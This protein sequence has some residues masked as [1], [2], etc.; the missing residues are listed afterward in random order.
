VPLPKIILS[1]LLTALVFFAIDMVWL[2]VVAKN[3]YQKHLGHLLRSD[4]NWVAAISFYLLFI[5]GILI[6]AV[7][8]AVEKES[9]QRALVLGALFG[10]IAY[11]TYD[12]T[13]LATLK[14]WPST[15]VWIDMAWGAILTASV[16][17]AGYGIIK[18]IINH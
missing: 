13:N 11:A 16:S 1:Y 12:L 3:L 17:A 18:F 2:G 8:P 14:S 6:F 15:I 9:L 5:V 7:F 10:F 4:V